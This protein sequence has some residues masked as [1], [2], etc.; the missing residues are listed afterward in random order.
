MNRL[1]FASAATLGCLLL[2][3][4]A[5]VFTIALASDSSAKPE[6]HEFIRQAVTLPD[7]DISVLVRK[8][9]WPVGYKSAPHTHKGPGPR[10]VMSGRVQI[11]DQGKIGQYSAGEVFWHPGGFPHTAENIADTPSEVLIIELLPK[12]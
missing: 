6:K 1:R 12:P 10:F 5:L 4:I 11:D 2:S 8:V 9:K 3:T 7:S